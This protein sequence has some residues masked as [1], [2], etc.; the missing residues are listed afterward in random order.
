M[1]GL[2]KKNHASVFSN[3]NLKIKGFFKVKECYSIKFKEQDQKVI[4]RLSRPLKRL[5]GFLDR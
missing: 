4:S 3:C 2:K 1:K 5:K